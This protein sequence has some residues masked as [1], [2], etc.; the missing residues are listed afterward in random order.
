MVKRK[1]LVYILFLLMLL[2]FGQ[3]K[4]NAETAKVTATNVGSYFHAHMESSSHFN[5]YGQILNTKITDGTSIG[6]QAYCIAPGEVA[7]RSR[8]YNV[9]DYNTND[10]LN[11]INNTQEKDTNKLTREQLNKMQLYAH[12]GYGYGSH[13]DSVYIVATQMLIYRVIE[14]TVFTTGL[15]DESGCTKVNDPAA[16]TNAMNEIQAL[17]DNHSM[18]PSFNGTEIKL[19]KGETLELEDTNNVLSSFVVKQCDNCNAQ[20]NG[21]KLS[22]ST[23]KG[24]EVSVVLEKNINTFNNSVLFLTLEDSQNFITSGN[25]D[26]IFARVSG[27]LSEGYI[28]INKVDSETNS[29]EAQGDAKLVGAV[30]G[31][32]NEEGEEV[33][34]LTIGSDCKAKSRA[35]EVGEY[36]VKEKS[37]NV[38]YKIDTR[39]YNVSIE[40]HEQVVSVTSR[41]DVYKFDFHLFKV[42]S[43][44]TTGEI[45]TEP[46]AVFDV[47]LI[48]K[49]KK[50][51][52]ITTDD[53]GRAKIT[54][55]YGKYSVCQTKGAE[56]SEDAKCFEIDIK[57][58]DVDKVIN[59]GPIKAR[60][61]VVKVDSKTE[62]TLP[63]AGIKFKI[64]NLDTNEY[65][66]QTISYP[67]AEKV[68]V[69]ET[70]S[71]GILYT[72]YP[73]EVGHYQLE[74]LD[75]VIYGYLWNSEPLKFEIKKDADFTYDDELG[76]IL[77][78]K[79]ANQEVR[80]K[81]VIYKKGE[82][83]VIQDGS[84]TYEEIVL[85]GIKFGLYDEEGNLIG[86]VI[87]NEDGYAEFT[88][89]KLGK[90][91]LKEI[92]TVDG[93]V[94]DNKEYEFN[95]EYKDQYTP[96][97]EQE[98]T[99]KNYLK[100]GKVEITKVD[101]SNGKPL[102]NTLIEV[103]TINDELIFS[104]RTDRY[105]KVIIEN[106]KAG[107]YY[108]LEKEAPRGYLLNKD[109]MFFEI[110]ENGEIIKSKMKDVPI[111][112]KLEFTKTD[113]STGEP[114]PNTLIEIYN[115]RGKLVFRGR[116]DENGKIVIRRLRYGRYYILEKEAPEG[117]VLNTEKMF[118]RIKRNGEVVKA[119]MEN[120]LITGT[121]EFTKV[122]ISTG[123]PL[124]NT[125]I[126]IYTD[127]DELIFSGLT[128]E[129]G[130]VIIENLKYGK[131]YILEK[132]APEG[133]ILNPEKMFFEIREDG[134]IVKS[135]MTDEKIPIPN[136]LSNSYFVYIPISLFILSS[137]ILIVTST[138]SKKKERE[139]K[140]DKKSK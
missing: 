9:Y 49:G 40:E 57:N 115:Y 25:V 105:G 41:E 114:L 129:N 39:S 111:T 93:Y 72:P 68:C 58:K 124:P 131:Y 18:T 116:T 133:Y 29:C 107:K 7:H 85:K 61:K 108:F 51:G 71:E 134:V 32:Y 92:E 101:I 60:I 98:I 21:N 95:L 5:H 56:D 47:T 89:L 128:D 28:E 54:L 1:N 112:G 87:T 42:K 113:L 12:Y 53:K 80:G 20:I 23:D 139:V 15:C 44:G 86:T 43:D 19:K 31:I 97:I 35:L 26:P 10:I 55:P 33:D 121:L 4:V 104:G 14:P 65:I 102:P 77:E 135:E 46:N 82:E 90:Y 73:L 81:I 66:C 83:F 27:E 79:F 94:L 120:K 70:T 74:E 69:F 78:V 37:P 91:I 38:G 3:E 8:Y 6:A 2:L 30:Y 117:Y 62:E 110:K 84:F 122:D 34:T 67:N 75:Q 48:S 24:G 99:L 118:F 50:M 64:K 130:K 36:T 126:E 76:V 63:I 136:T 119:N 52:T 11:L 17:V 59:N 127:K 103:Y 140:N 88:D 125:L 100:K 109:K 137:G 45:E 123:E 16:V 13:S 138:L 22:I 106:L 96:I 132:Q